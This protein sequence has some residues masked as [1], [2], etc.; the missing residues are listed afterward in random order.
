MDH[1]LSDILQIENIGTFVKTVSAYLMTLYISPKYPIENKRFCLFSHTP[2]MQSRSLYTFSY[3]PVQRYKNERRRHCAS[4]QQQRILQCSLTFN[5][6]SII[7]TLNCSE[8]IIFIIFCK[9]I[10]KGLVGF[11]GYRGLMDSLTKKEET[12]QKETLKM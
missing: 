8:C 10:Q 12:K 1:V 9:S 2:A 5:S 3:A 4:C 7:L 6:R 11:R